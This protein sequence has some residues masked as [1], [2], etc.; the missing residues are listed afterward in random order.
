M[1]KLCSPAIIYLLFSI[2]QIIIDTINKNYN[3]AFMKII[4]TIM[5]TILL[6][7]LCERGLNVISWIIVFIP[8]ILMTVIVSMLLYVFGLDASSGTINYDCKDKYPDTV[9]IDSQGNIIIYNPYY[10]PL[11]NPVRYN[12]P[13]IIVP[14]PP[15]EKT[16]V[17]N[18]NTNTVIIN[19]PPRFSTDRT[20]RS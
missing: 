15:T 3:T 13:N 18:T 20:Y 10:N 16:T 4:V 8:F 5:V 2:T 1:I 12:P 9:K 14:K 7:I 6:Y 19:N 11:V 17:K